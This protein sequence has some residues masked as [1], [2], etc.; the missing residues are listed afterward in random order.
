MLLHE[1]D[2]DDEIENAIIDSAIANVKP[3]SVSSRE[4]TAGTTASKTACTV[5][6][7]RNRSA[8]VYV[9]QLSV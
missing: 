8:A 2:S 1:S 7:L 9:L 4:G 6:A 3:I 5:A